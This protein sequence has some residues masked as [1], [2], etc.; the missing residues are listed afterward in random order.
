MLSTHFRHELEFVSLVISNLTSS[1][2]E[3]LK[4]NAAGYDQGMQVASVHRL[5]QV[6]ESLMKWETE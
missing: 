1:L 5:M 3:H 2:G 6:M 4:P